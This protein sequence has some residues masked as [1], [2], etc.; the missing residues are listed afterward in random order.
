VKLELFIPAGVFL[1]VSLPVVWLL[2]ALEM[3]GDYRVW[4]AI[5]VGAIA[6]GYAQ[7]R[8]AAKAENAQNKSVNEEQQA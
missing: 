1:A 8:L 2:N 4:I 7:S 3:G 5:G 6:T